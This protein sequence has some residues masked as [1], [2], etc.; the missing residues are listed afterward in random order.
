MAVDDASNF[1]QT[2]S[3]TEQRPGS[4][5]THCWHS[6]HRTVHAHSHG[7]SGSTNIPPKP[8]IEHIPPMY[9]LS[10]WRLKLLPLLTP[11]EATLWQ[12]ENLRCWLRRWEAQVLEEGLGGKCRTGGSSVDVW[13]AGWLWEELGGSGSRT[14]KLLVCRR[15]LSLGPP[16]LTDSH[17]GCPR[18]GCRDRWMAA[19]QPRTGSSDPVVL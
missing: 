19:P 9:L 8:L 6:P 7:L 4:R 18:L 5:L 3:L 1:Q 15:E 17:K 11:A 10:P 13:V 16:L 2:K 12:A 14:G